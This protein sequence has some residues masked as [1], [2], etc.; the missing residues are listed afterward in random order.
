MQKT[1]RKVPEQTYK[2]LKDCPQLRNAVEALPP[3][4]YT[5]RSPLR[6]G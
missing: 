6:I 5:G 3:R 4:P 1:E 2:E